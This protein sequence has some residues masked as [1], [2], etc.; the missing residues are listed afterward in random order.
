MAT[1]L[2]PAT[3]IEPVLVS[4]SKWREKLPYQLR[5]Y[6]ATFGACERIVGGRR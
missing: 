3:T 6:D 4:G 1:K 2:V 5:P